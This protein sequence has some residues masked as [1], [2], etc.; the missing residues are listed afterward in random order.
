MYFIVLSTFV[1][2]FISISHLFCLF[3]PKRKDYRVLYRSSLGSLEGGEGAQD[4]QAVRLRSWRGKQR[5]WEWARL[6]GLFWQILLNCVIGSLS[7]RKYYSTCACNS[8]FILLTFLY[9]SQKLCMTLFS[10][11]VLWHPSLSTRELWKII[12]YN[13]VTK[14]YQGFFLKPESMHTMLGFW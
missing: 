6:C 12:L 4:L 8:Q 3:Q 5:F 7:P 13:N 14:D 2:C 9:S 1:L 10:M 11:Y